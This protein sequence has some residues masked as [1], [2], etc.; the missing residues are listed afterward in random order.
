MKSSHLDVKI[1]QIRTKID[2]NYSKSLDF[3][4]NTD[5][6]MELQKKLIEELS[7]AVTSTMNDMK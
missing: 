6:R 4:K 3:H 2:Q 5:F 1:D 7:A